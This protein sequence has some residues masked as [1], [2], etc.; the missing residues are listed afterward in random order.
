MKI[1]PK[2]IARALVDAMEASPDVSVD[3]ACESAIVLLRKAVPGFP[4]RTFIKIVEREME[5][6]GNTA[7]GLLIVP[8]EKSLKAEA[9][10]PL[11]QAKSDK[12]V[13]VDRK[14]NPDLIGGAV[15]HIDHRRL[16][17]SIQGALATL[18]RTCL[19]PL[20]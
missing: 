1:T 5:K 20:D 13:H 6:R 7:S 4:A 3:D 14:T 15:L 16:D 17:C 9:I 18:L 11:L 10:I 2:E 19:Q 8:H 12:T